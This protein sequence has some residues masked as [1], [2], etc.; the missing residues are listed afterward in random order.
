MNYRHAFHAGNF[1]DLVKHAM[2]LDILGVLT[3]QIRG[4]SVIDTHAGAGLY[5]LK[6]DAAVRTGEAEVGIRRLM[7]DEA[8]PDEFGALRAAVRR[9]NGAGALRY[10]PGS[11]L[12]IAEA[13]RVRDTYLAC[14]L[15]P[16]DFAALKSA[17]PRQAGVRALMADGWREARSAIPSA[18]APCLIL[19]DPPFERGDDLAQAVALSGL[20]LAR[21]PGAVVAIWTPIKDL[22][23]FDAFL[24]D[25][26]DTVAAAPMIA[27]QVRLRPLT[28]P[29]KLNGCAMI[30]INP[31]AGLAIR[32]RAIV[33]WVASAAGEVGALG[34]VDLLQ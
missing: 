25:L 20:A 32:S 12:L 26:E 2:L 13:L 7:G 14:E 30:V 23:A 11:P 17:L 15:H 27:A 8:A 31:T 4:L 34:R 16:E 18:P 22:A 24:G 33:D 3:G 5:D 21:N 29:M 1:A 19:I 28:D 10:Y 6:S 9:A